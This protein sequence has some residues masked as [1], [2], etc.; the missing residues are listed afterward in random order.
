MSNSDEVRW[1]QRLETFGSALA[2]LTVACRQ[3]NYSE[4]ERAGLV[5]LFSLTFELAWKTVKDLLHCEGFDAKTPR[6]VISRSFEVEYL[7]KADCD[8]LLNVLDNRDVLARIYIDELA[9]EAEK[10]IKRNYQP[11]LIRLHKTL[12]IMSQK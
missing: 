4:L 7:S 3:S 10:L 11:A 2:G 9:E 1:L 6:S 8:I 5:Q 12:T